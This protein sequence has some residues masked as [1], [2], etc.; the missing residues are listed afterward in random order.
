MLWLGRIQGSP[1]GGGA[2][3]EVELEEVGER[4]CRASRA[5]LHGPERCLGRPESQQSSWL[6]K[7]P[8][9]GGDDWKGRSLPNLSLDCNVHDSGFLDPE[10]QRLHPQNGG[11]GGGQSQHRA[12]RGVSFDGGLFL[13]KAPQPVNRRA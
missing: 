5:E 13:P 2:E 9:E 7:G 3:L 10:P 4:H 1:P 12:H 8:G 11:W 6:A